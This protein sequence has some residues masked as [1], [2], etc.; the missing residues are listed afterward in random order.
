LDFYG[1][2]NDLNNGVIRA[3]HS[4]SFV[5]DP[6]RILR[7]IRFEQRLNF[8]IEGRTGELIATH[9]EMLR[10]ITGERVRN[11]LTLLLREELPERGIF[12]LHERGLLVAIHPDLTFT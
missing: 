4:L 11:E 10:R 12:A 8:T 1:G 3:L 5:D 2:M 9:R 6:T 7:A